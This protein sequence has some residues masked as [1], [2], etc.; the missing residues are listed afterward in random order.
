MEGQTYE[1]DPTNMDVIVAIN[2]L[3]AHMDEELYC[4]REELRT[5]RSL[6]GQSK[7]KLSRHAERV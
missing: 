1:L 3:A 7:T 4:M 2:D 6:I 5:L